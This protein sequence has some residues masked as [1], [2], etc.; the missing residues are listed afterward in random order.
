M[1]QLE[2]ET[3]GLIANDPNIATRVVGVR[4]AGDRRR[5]LGKK[6]AATADFQQAIAVAQTLPNA[7]QD[8]TIAIV[9]KMKDNLGAPATIIVV[10][11]L[12]K[13]PNVAQQTRWKVVLGLLYFQNNE[14]AKAVSTVQEAVA[15]SATLEE[16]N[17]LS[18]LNVAGLVY[19]MAGDRYDEA[20]TTYE[21]LLAKRPDDVAR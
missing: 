20:R 17:Q 11:N 2:T 12:M 1:A 4:Q 21:Q 9:D 18:A 5:N 6:E 15:Q 7:A 13:T 8:V 10:Q 3:K 19:M 16:P 14:K